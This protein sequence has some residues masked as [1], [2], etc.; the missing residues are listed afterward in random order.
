[1]TRRDMNQHIILGG[2]RQPFAVDREIFKL[3]GPF[4]A[5]QLTPDVIA[6]AT[7][8]PSWASGNCA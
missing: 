7:T 1:M 6:K 4:A 8:A 3:F 5:A 2:R